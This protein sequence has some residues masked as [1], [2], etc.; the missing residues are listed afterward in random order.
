MDNF[1]I[2]LLNNVK[3]IICKNNTLV[4]RSVETSCNDAR[5]YHQFCTMF[6]LKQIIKSSTQRVSISEN[7][8]AIVFKTRLIL[9]ERLTAF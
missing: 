8:A 6:S 7:K 1:N 3:Y 4:S 5:N 9:K 2:N